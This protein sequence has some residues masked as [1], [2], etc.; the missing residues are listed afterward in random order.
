MKKNIITIILAILVLIFG[1]YT[2]YDLLKGKGDSNQDVEEKDKDQIG[3]NE[4]EKNGN[5]LND[6][7]TPE[8]YIDTEDGKKN[9]VEYFDNYLKIFFP[10]KSNS[11]FL[12]NIDNF[13]NEEITSFLF[14]HYFYLGAGRDDYQIT[15]SKN[16]IDE[17]V[18]E[19]F[20]ILN[21][22]ILVNNNEFSGI[23]KIDDSTY[24]IYWSPTGFIAQDCYFES[25]FIY[26]ENKLK[27]TYI[28]DDSS[29]TL[30]NVEKG[31]LIFY[32]EYNDENYNL[33][34]IEFNKD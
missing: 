33:K 25:L 10:S 31:T 20:G 27:V 2:T 4:P 18:Y 5:A 6:K 8:V 13:G 15:V 14:W 16:E 22:K 32:L 29:N 26:D 30:D 7:Y 34:K 3:E 28:V 9:A 21:Y 17:L 12:K 11:Q 24:Q 19:Y 23:K 1:T